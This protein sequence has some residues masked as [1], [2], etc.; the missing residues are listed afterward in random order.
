MDSNL[1]PVLFRY[2]ARVPGPVALVGSFNH[3]NPRT[4]PLKR[5]DRDWRIVVYLPPGTYPYAFFTNGRLVRDPDAR[6]SFFSAP[7]SLLTIREH[8]PAGRPPKV[9]RSVDEACS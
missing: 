8:N 9:R 3:W 2:R 4:H 5:V 7:Y 1:R 6:R